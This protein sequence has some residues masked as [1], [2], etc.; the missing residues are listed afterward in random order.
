MYKY[1][2]VKYTVKKIE[3]RYLSL[4]IWKNLFQ[5]FENSET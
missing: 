2:F 3:I 1:A 4:K 5:I